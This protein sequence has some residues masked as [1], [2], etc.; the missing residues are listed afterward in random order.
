MIDLLCRAGFLPDRVFWFRKLILDLSTFGVLK[1]QEKMTISPEVSFSL[2]S[3]DN[4][5]L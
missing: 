5:D 3:S 2:A 4:K 1:I